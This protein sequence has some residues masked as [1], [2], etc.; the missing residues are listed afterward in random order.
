MFSYLQP[1]DWDWAARDEHRVDQPDGETCCR[2]R[3]RRW[4]LDQPPPNWP[5][6]IQWVNTFFFTFLLAIFCQTLTY[7][8]AQCTICKINVSIVICNL[9]FADLTKHPNF[10]AA[11]SQILDSPRLRIFS[12]RYS[13][14]FFSLNSFATRL[15]KHYEGCSA[16][17]RELRTTQTVVKYPGTRTASTGLF[18]PW[19]WEHKVWEQTIWES[20]IWG[21]TNW[22]YWTVMEPM[23]MATH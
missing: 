12:S 15:T 9:Q 23:K 16:N 4:C 3:R 18:N 22:Q 14:C 20:T 21:Q 6:Y 13:S 2:G 8:H 7:Q 19:R 1:L 17:C 11:A 5:L 10:L